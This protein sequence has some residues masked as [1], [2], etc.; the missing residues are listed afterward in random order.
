MSNDADEMLAK[1]YALDGTRAAPKGQSEN[2]FPKKFTTKDWA[3][4]SQQDGKWNSS[5]LQT[6]KNLVAVVC[7]QKIGFQTSASGPPPPP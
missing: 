4:R 5:L 2:L 6:T 1:L 7:D 3:A